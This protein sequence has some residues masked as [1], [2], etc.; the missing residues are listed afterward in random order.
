MVVKVLKRVRALMILG[1][2]A[3]GMNR[4]NSFKELE[5]LGW[6]DLLIPFRAR[7]YYQTITMVPGT[8]LPAL[9]LL[10]I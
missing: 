5:D 10:R 4:F 2:I 9:G 7:E 8:C 1:F 6:E 3:Y